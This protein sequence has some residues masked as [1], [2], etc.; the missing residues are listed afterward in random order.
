MVA[1]AADANND[2]ATRKPL[3]TAAAGHTWLRLFVGVVVGRF[4]VGVVVDLVWKLACPATTIESV[5]TKRIF[6][7]ISPASGQNT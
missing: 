4:V 2:A 6:Q 1:D 5:T 7:P 3:A